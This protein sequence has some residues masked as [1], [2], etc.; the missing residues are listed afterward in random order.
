MSVGL[1][2]YLFKYA[3]EITSGIIQYTHFYT[4]T[5]YPEYIFTSKQIKQ[6]NCNDS[7]V[8]Y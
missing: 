8:D 7:V 3:W 2:L 5:N 1:G 4:H 6:L